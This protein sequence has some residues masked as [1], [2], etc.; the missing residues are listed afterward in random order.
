[1]TY[2]RWIALFSSVSHIKASASVR[3]PAISFSKRARLPARRHR[4]CLPHPASPARLTQ[5]ESRGLIEIDNN[6]SHPEHPPIC[7]AGSQHRHPSPEETS[8]MQAILNGEST[9]IV[10]MIVA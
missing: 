8:T 7:K 9:L 3:L 6:C 4:P 5:G 2:S 10:A 1:M